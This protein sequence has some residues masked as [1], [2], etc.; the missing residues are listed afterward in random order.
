MA[1]PAAH[2]RPTSTRP[3][4]AW[5]NRLVSRRMGL[6]RHDVAFLVAARRLGVSYERTLMIGRA[7]LPT[8]VNFTA[9]F[10]TAGESLTST[11]RDRIL[12][13]GGGFADGLFRYLGA[14]TIDSLD[15]TDWEGNSIVHD[16]NEPLRKELHSQYTAVFDCGTLEHVFNF[17][18]ALAN[19]L[20]AVSVGGHFLG[21]SPTNNWCGHGFYQFSPE[22]YYGVLGSSNGYELRCMLMRSVHLGARWYRVADPAESQAKPDGPWNSS[23]YT[24]A[25]RVSQRDI[26]AIKPQQSKYAA[27]WEAERRR[28]GSHT[29]RIHARA[30]RLRTK[31]PASVREPYYELRRTLRPAVRALKDAREL[32]SRRLPDLSEL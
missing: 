5:P 17:P 16:L 21:V 10:R 26:L 14:T 25:R 1:S 20:N 12:A 32:R 11:D 8:R 18:I 29:Q 6:D 13:D 23:L 7:I 9:A 30:G 22:A 19:C 15:A 28:P 24:V 27:V 2:H 4:I 31:I 3:A